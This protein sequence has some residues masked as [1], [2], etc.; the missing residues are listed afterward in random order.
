VWMWVRIDLR[1]RVRA[2]AVLALL[3][4]LS[5]GV[6]LAAIAGARRN[7]T[8]VDR[9]A[10]RSLTAD[11]WALA[12]V[13]GMDWNKVRQLPYVETV[14][15][16]AVAQYDV[17]GFPPGLGFLPPASRELATTVERG[18]IVEGRR[19]DPDRIDEVMASPGARRIGIHVGTHLS[20]GGWRADKLAEYMRMSVTPPA[21][22]PHVDATVVGILKSPFFSGDG[23]AGILPSWRFYQTYKANIPSF[24]NSINAVVRFRGG[25]AEFSQFGKDIDRIAGRPVEVT[26][27]KDVLATGRKATNLERTALL[28]F[29]FAAAVAALVLVGQAVIRLVASSAADGPVLGAMGLTT[30][31]RALGLAIPPVIAGAFGGIFGVVLAVAASGIFP[32]ATARRAEPSPGLEANWA[33]LGLGFLAVLVVVVLG[34]LVSAWWDVRRGERDRVPRQSR[35]ARAIREA[36][37]PLPLS[38][39]AQ[40]ALERGRGRSAVPVLPALIGA[41]VGVLGVVGTLTFRAGL[42]HATNDIHLFGQQFQAVASFDP[43]AKVDPA[44]VQ[45]LVSDQGVQTVN[46]DPIAVVSVNGRAVT[47]FA[48]HALKGS[49]RVVT[50]S[51]RAPRAAG[52]IT[53]APSEASALH[54]HTGDTVRVGDTGAPYRLVGVGFTPV[55]SHTTYDQ[56]AWMTLEGQRAVVPKSGYKYLRYDV[57]FGRRVDA[58]AEAGRLGT[59]APASLDLVTPPANSDNLKGVRQVPLALGVFLA[60]LAIAAV[61]HALASAVRRRRRDIA[62]MRS[63]G[64]T[65]RQARLTVVAQATTL[66]LVGLVFGLPL[67]LLAGRAIWHNVATST[68]VVYVPPL[69]AAALVLAV[70]AA[71]LIANALAAWPARRAARLRA[72]EVLRTE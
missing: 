58:K 34:V 53:L 11:A 23:G 61:G 30:R 63:I 44:F 38:M 15:E 2:L 36:G 28:A 70:P 69:A 12:N 24:A 67:G 31:Q 64:F 4:A 48:L 27:A 41:I 46:E 13:P 49:T 14:G 45:S 18:V 22:G 35:M 8:A 1:R 37:S 51:G 59:N 55:D 62:V 10:Q 52:E 3:V 19:S 29:A 71:L 16:F 43:D 42:D 66:A 50:L 17:R 60:L 72:A 40:L 56:G 5:S 47:V 32:I 9:L 33:I 6:V 25:D 21:D 65:R 54:V 20:I 68:P 39:G 26:R 57:E 7:G